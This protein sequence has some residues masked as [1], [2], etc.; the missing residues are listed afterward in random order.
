MT[1]RVSL[2]IATYNHAELLG[3]TLESIFRQKVPFPLEVIV[4][5]DASTDDTRAVLN[6][7]PVAALNTGDYGHGY[8]NGVTAKNLALRAA[9][10]DIV[11]QQSD[12]VFHVS[13]NLIEAL[14][15]ALQPGEFVLCTVHGWDVPTGTLN[16]QY[17]GTDNPRPLLFLGATWREDVCRIG[18]YEPEL[19]EVTW[20]DDNAFGDGL[21]KGLGLKHRFLPL[22]A[23][24]QDH[25]RI[26]DRESQ[27]KAKAIYD[28]KIA[29]QQWLSSTGP[30]PFVS[31]TS[32]E[33]SNSREGDN[34]PEQPTLQE[35]WDQYGYTS[36]KATFHN[37]I[38]IY[39]E[40]FDPY[41]DAETRYLEIGIGWGDCL[42][43]WS[44][45]F[46]N[47]TVVGLE[48]WPHHTER[49]GK[50]SKGKVRIVEGRSESEEDCE[51]LFAGESF[52]IIVDDGDHSLATQL[53]TLEVYG[54]KVRPGGLY[55]IEDIETWEN[56]QVIRGMGFE[57]LDLRP[58]RP[59]APDNIL[60]VKRY[61]K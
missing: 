48:A 7:F 34:M 50:L 35:I 6:R 43:A 38:D 59:N 9:H 18:G 3:R 53:K 32:V 2:C 46:V 60:A 15:A 58:Q 19:A 33:F 41:R 14:V 25:S 5:D 36:D 49:V 31:G 54:K 30:W 28:R 23:L 52:D 16:W 1:E 45:Y 21:I 24:H 8:H 44:H 51:R 61:P 42:V 47:G 22:L 37:F 27:S 20:Y 11:I 12:D 40:W 17:T 10:G 55:I 39:A 4:A 56:A 57:V 26:D 29:R 13:P